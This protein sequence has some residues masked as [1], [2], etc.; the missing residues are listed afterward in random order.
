MHI[1]KI[2][3]CINMHTYIC[4]YIY[5][6][7]Y[8]IGMIV[9]VYV[10]EQVASHIL[11]ILM[12]DYISA[13]SNFHISFRLKSP[14]FAPSGCLLIGIKCSNADQRYS[15]TAILIL[16]EL[17]LAGKCVN[18]TGVHCFGISTNNF[19]FIYV[20]FFDYFSFFFAISSSLTL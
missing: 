3:I 19:L 15:V 10:Y 13:R 17:Q 8:C 9:C 2:E 14:C 7:I 20:L 16:S 6:Y 11:C 5:M 12:A 4:T 1:F 18:T